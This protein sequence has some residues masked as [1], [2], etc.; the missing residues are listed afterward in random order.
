MKDLEQRAREFSCIRFAEG[1]REVDVR[2][3]AEYS[4]MQ[5]AAEM[6]GD[7][8]A[9]RFSVQHPDTEGQGMTLG[10]TEHEAWANFICVCP[11]TDKKRFEFEK[12]DYEGKG[13]RAIQL[14][15]IKLPLPTTTD[16]KS[17]VG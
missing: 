14:A 4:F 1:T 8:I 15:I 5:G 3:V 13:Y 11:L 2:N 17:E 7:V 10:H 12:A 16:C 9:R 6:M